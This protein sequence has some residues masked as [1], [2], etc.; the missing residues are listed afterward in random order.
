AFRTYEFNI[1]DFVQP[2]A[3][4]TL[5]LEITAPTETDLGINWVDWN[6]TPPDKNLGLWRE[7]FITTSGPV[8]L[9]Y[10]Q[11]VTHL[12]QANLDTARLTV[13]AELSNAT[14]QPVTGI[15]RGSFER[16]TFEQPV[17][18]AP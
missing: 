2:G 13:N 1:T 11:V 8:A 9:R 17:A 6:P 16:I 10:P 14:D 3:R 18:L 7:V 15:L 5:A 4:N 12:D